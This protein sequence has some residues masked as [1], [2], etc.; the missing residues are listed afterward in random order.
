MADP[1][2]KEDLPRHPD[3]A[4]IKLAQALARRHAA[5]DDKK[6]G[7]EHDGK[8]SEPAG[9]HGIREPSR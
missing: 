1:A 7:S 3:P 6:E 4:I 8:Q 2:A 9:A 5:E